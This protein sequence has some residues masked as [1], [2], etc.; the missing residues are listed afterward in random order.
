MLVSRTAGIALACSVA[1]V[2]AGSMPAQVVTTASELT[3][4]GTAI[5]PVSTASTDAKVVGGARDNAVSAIG[6]LFPTLASPGEAR[7]IPGSPIQPVALVGTGSAAAGIGLAGLLVTGS[8]ALGTG[9]VAVAPWAAGAGTGSAALGAGSAAAAPVGDLL[10]AAALAL[11][12]GS[13]AAGASGSAASGGLGTPLAVLGTGSAALGTGS[14]GLAAAGTGVA[15]F[16]ALAGTGSAA[17]GAGSAAVAPA[18]AA[19]GTGLATLI[20]TGSAALG[21]GSAASPVAA[22]NSSDSSEYE[23]LGLGPAN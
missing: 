11:G 6:L 15:P 12:T 19:T 1:A 8:A 14:A 18:G 2:G 22:E 3:Q 10:G 9:S 20:A 23:P 13:A 21:S 7:L 5:E 16:A 17:L 4:V